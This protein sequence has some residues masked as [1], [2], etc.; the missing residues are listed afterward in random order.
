MP[1]WNG[2]KS[3]SAKT[4]SGSILIG[5]TPMPSGLSA[6][7]GRYGGLRAGWRVLDVACGAGRH[8]RAFVARRRPVFR[9]RSL[10]DPAATGP[11]GHRCPAGPGRH[12]AAAHP[13]RLHGPHRQSLHQLRLLRADAEHARALREMIATVR[14]G[15]WFVIDFLNPAAVRRQLVPRGNAGA[16]RLAR[17]RSPGRCRPTAD[18]S[19]RA[20]GRRRVDI[21]RERVR[22]FEPEQIAGMLEAAGRDGPVSL[23]RLRRGAR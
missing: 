23:W 15:G 13:P 5:T 17:S 8:A 20:F 16:G 3:G 10:R 9:A 21:I 19:A 12:A 6:L 1:P 2:S 7:I 22:L 14:P 18:T 11:A 4:T